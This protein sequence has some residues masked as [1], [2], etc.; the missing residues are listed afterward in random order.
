PRAK[1]LLRRLSRRWGRAVAPR[2][3]L[4]PPRHSTCLSAGRLQ[5]IAQHVLLAQAETLVTTRARNPEHRRQPRHPRPRQSRTGALMLELGPD[6]LPGLVAHLDHVETL[7][8][9]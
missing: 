2:L 4:A 9:G 3:P 1:N 5:Q 7:N 6:Q 8:Q